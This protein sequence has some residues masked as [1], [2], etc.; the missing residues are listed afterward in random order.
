MSRDLPDIRGTSHMWFMILSA[1]ADIINYLPGCSTD[2][3]ETQV[4][5]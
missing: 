1:F 5:C 4:N 2:I 3:S